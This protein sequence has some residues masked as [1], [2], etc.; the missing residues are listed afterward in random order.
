MISVT[1]TQKH[2][3]KDDI[4]RGTSKQYCDPFDCPLYRALKEQHPSFEFWSI[5]AGGSIDARQYG[6]EHH[7]PNGGAA[8][9]N[10]YVADKLLTGKIKSVTLNYNI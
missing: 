4:E 7:V 8:H 2:F 5:G 10:S 6:G 3:N 1:I 9:W